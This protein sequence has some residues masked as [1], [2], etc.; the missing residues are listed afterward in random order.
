MRSMWSAASGMKN[1]QLAMDTISNNLANVNT[2]GFKTQRMEFQDIMYQTLQEASVDGGEGKPVPVEVGYGVKASAT[3]R[4]FDTG[5]FQQTE[6][7]LD[8]L[9]NGDQF[10]V[11]NDQN[12]EERYTKDGSFKLSFNNDEVS[13]VTSDGY[14][15]QGVDGNLVL[16]EDVTAVQVD[17][18]G[19]VNVQRNGSDTYENIGQMKLAQFINPA[20]LEGIGSNLF[21]QS[22]ASGTAYT[23]IENSDRSEI[24]QG[25]LESSNVQVVDEMV[26]MITVQRAYE[27]NSK[28]IQTADSML[29]VANSL[30]R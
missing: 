11:V 26:N 9:V 14:Y 1:L 21:A 24:W 22:E 2:T 19:M 3:L 17:G 30:K 4:N 27:T 10:F 8:C 7:E 6:N 13:I 25:F 28:S 29:E 20:G 15:V 18:M 23:D 16:G 12:G 5:S